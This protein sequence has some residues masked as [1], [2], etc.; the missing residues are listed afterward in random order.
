MLNVENI[1]SGYV[2]NISVN[3]SMTTGASL[4]F[5]GRSH[6]HLQSI[7]CSGHWEDCRSK[8]VVQTAD[9]S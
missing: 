9:M 5:K 1:I 2:I 4:S 8:P 7:L 3:I 6:L